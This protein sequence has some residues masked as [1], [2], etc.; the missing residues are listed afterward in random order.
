MPDPVRRRE[1]GPPNWLDAVTVLR[2]EPATLL[3][4]FL[5]ARTNVLTCNII[6]LHI[7]MMNMLDKSSL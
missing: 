4:L 7:V 1:T 3:S 5:S 6:S 2:V